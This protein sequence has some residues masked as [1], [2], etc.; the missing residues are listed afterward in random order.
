[1]PGA[2]LDEEVALS[3]LISFQIPEDSAHATLQ[4]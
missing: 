3:G 2:F 4:L 1:M